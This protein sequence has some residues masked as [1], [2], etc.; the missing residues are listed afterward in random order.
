[1]NEQ[2]QNI[3]QARQAVVVSK[4]IL[5]DTPYYKGYDSLGKK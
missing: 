4:I 3:E 1:M 5:I 2:N